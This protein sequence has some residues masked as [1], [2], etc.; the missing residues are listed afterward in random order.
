MDEVKTVEISQR[1]FTLVAAIVI[2]VA[3]FLLATI[4]YQFKSLPENAPQDITVSGEGKAYIKPDVAV[5]TFG[6][7]TQGLNSQDVV[8]R[9]NQI[10]SLVTKSVRNLGVEEKDIQTT[11]YNLLPQYDY[12]ERG[13]VFRGYT[14]DQQIS[15]K[16]RNFDK[17]SAILDSAA[18]SG[19][20]TIGDLRFTVDDMEK[21]KAEAH[22][23][24]IAQAK[25]KAVSLFKQSGLHI[26]KLVDIQEGY[27][28]SMQPYNYGIGGAALDKAVMPSS[29]PEIQVGQ[30]EVITTVNLTYRVR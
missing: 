6:A 15:V 25:E 10:M 30:T 24:A 26:V 11:M 22:E 19:A 20:N 1:L 27:N 17:I 14:L 18:T 12:T 2:M 29:A 3:I 13:R 4:L 21:V 9:N 5:I 23:K 7:Q 16:I 28:P 8:N